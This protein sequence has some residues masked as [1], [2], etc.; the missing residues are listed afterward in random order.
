ME[1]CVRLPDISLL[2]TCQGLGQSN[3]NSG[4]HEKIPGRQAPKPPAQIS[5]RHTISAFQATIPKLCPSRVER[6]AQ[7][8]KGSNETLTISC[9]TGLKLSSLMSSMPCEH[10]VPNISPPRSSI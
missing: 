1:G 7:A 6:A 4:G 10:E 2:V 9:Y 8:Q 5:P 3:I